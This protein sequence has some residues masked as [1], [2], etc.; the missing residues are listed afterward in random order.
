MRS[1]C[2]PA[3]R[4]GERWR[5]WIPALVR[6][7]GPLRHTAPDL[8]E[9]HRTPVGPGLLAGLGTDGPAMTLPTP[10]EAVVT[11]VPD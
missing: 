10:E 5:S 11:R 2:T 9:S 4:A 3:L 6:L 7:P 1:P 8:G